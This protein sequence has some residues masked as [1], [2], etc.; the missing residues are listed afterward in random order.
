MASTSGSRNAPSSAKWTVMV[1]MGAATVEGEAPLFD[2]A[3][4]DLAEMRF[5]GSGYGDRLDIFV[6]VHLGSDLVP[7]RGHITEEY[8]AWY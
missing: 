5:V 4:D 8:A 6:Q 2:A 7:R 1:F 3:E